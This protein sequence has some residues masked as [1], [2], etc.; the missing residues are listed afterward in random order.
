M[1]QQISYLLLDF[2]ARYGIEQLAWYYSRQRACFI[3]P[4][5]TLV[6]D[7][8][9]MRQKLYTFLSDQKS[10]PGRERPTTDA[11]SHLTS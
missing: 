8:I 7:V 3:Y 10:R 2:D 5:E 1:Y 4:V 9:A 11:Q 6:P